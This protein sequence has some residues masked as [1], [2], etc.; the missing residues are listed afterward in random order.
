[1]SW[2]E[3]QFVDR[4]LERAVSEC[5]HVVIDGRCFQEVKAELAQNEVEVMRG[6]DGLIHWLITKGF[7]PEVE[8]Q[9]DRD[10][11]KGA[12]TFYQLRPVECETTEPKPKPNT[13]EDLRRWIEAGCPT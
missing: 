12:S 4:L 11:F 13:V 9:R 5:G 8:I 7:D 2:I 3:K 10:I 6:Q 1:M